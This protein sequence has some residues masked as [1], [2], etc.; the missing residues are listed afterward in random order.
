MVWFLCEANLGKL[1]E[2]GLLIRGIGMKVGAA[3]LVKVPA[4]F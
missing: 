3:R 1:Q 4:R 2:A